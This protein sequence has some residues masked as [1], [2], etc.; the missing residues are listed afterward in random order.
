MLEL[1]KEG[2]ILDITNLEFE[3]EG[4]LNP[5]VLQEGETVHV[6]YRAI[7]KGNHS[8][9]GY[10]KLDGPLT[11]AHRNNAP[12]LIPNLEYESRGMEDPRMVKIDN[13][14]Y[15]TFT[16][17]DGVN[18]MG[19]LATSKDLVN[20]ERQ[21]IIVPKITYDEFHRMAESNKH[22]NEKYKR[23][24]IQNNPDKRNRN[25]VLLSDKNVVFFPRKIKGQFY[26]LHRIKPDIQLVAVNDLK[27]LTPSYWQDYLMHFEKHILMAPKH[28]HE[29]S[30]IGAGCPP[31]ETEAGWL[32]IYHGV[33]DTVE[34]YVYTACAA[35]LDLNDPTKE[36]ARLPYPLIKPEHPWELKGEVNNVVFPTGTSLFGDRLYIYYGAADTRIAVA[37]VSIS[38]LITELLTHRA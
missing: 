9:V 38:A 4:V 18:A 8:T 20:F 28:G 26:F 16:A 35:L 31:I 25:K 36:L 34:G 7:R 3:N 11:V 22:L 13:L 12:L 15:M 33:H 10:C 27:E 21:G 19:S 30:Y 1:K 37:S 29:I 5:A 17:Y 23:F 2:V 6:F 24:H 14:Y 32:L